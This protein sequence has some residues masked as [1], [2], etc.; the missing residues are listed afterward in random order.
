ML[1]DDDPIIVEMKYPKTASDVKKIFF[2]MLGSFILIILFLGVLNLFLEIIINPP[3]NNDEFLLISIFFI[4]S[5]I[6]TIFLIGKNFYKRIRFLII[7]F[8]GKEIIYLY[9]TSI[10]LVKKGI[11]KWAKKI[12]IPDINDI[13]SNEEIYIKF[14]KS[15]IHYPFNIGHIEITMNDNSKIYFGECDYNKALSYIRKSFF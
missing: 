14:N 2:T 4:L 6:I 9:P 5:S 3:R 10:I 1:L 11:F 15:L 13:Y 8:I 12:M 7:Y